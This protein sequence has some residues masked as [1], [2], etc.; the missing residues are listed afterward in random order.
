MDLF[1]NTEHRIKQLRKALNEHNYKYYVLN[2]PS[3]SD[4]EYDQLMQ[5]LINLESAHPEYADP[6]SPSLRIGDDRTREFEQVVHKYPVLSLSNT[7][8][9]EEIIEFENRIKKTGLSNYE[10]VCELKYDGASISLTYENGKLLQAVT[11]GDGVSGDNIIANVKTIKSIPL[12]LTGEDY[13]LLFEIRGEIFIPHAGFEQMNREREETGEVPFANPRNAASGTLKIQNSSLVAKRKLDCFLYYLLGQNLPSDSHYENLKKAKEWGFKISEHV[14]KCITLDDVFKF[15]DYWEDSRKTLPYD[16]DGIVIKIDSYEQQNSLG[17]TA[18]SPRWA[19]AFKYKAE[20]AVT[21]L[22]SIDYQV[23]RTGAITPVANLEPVILA[24]TTVKRASLHNADQIIL[25][26]VRINDIV[27]IE[28]GGEIIPKVVGVEKSKRDAGSKTVKYIE[29][30]PECGTKLVRKEGEAKHYCPNEDGCPPQIKGKIEH[31]VSRRA[32][33]I[34]LAEAT[35]SQLYESGLVKNIADLYSLTKD[36]LINLERFAD[37]SAENL[38]ASINDS[39]DV[40]FDR[41]LYALGIRYAGETVAKKIATHFGSLYKLA[42]ANF[43]DL[44]DVEE[45]GDKIAESIIYYFNNEKNITIIKRLKEAGLQLNIKKESTERLS[46]ILE[47]KSIIISGVFRK[48][49]RDEIKKLIEKNGGK[50]VSSISA[51]TDFLIAGEKTGPSKL[52]KAQKLNI[53]IISED[54]FLDMINV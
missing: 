38:I 5:E 24:G 3:I 4:F 51:R 11:R 37:K 12:E 30:C 7:Y 20:Q 1:S 15:I 39:K 26:D 22:L 49:S 46:D 23:G 35:I 42:E 41:V 21:R 36:Q 10:Y 19:I 18:K 31:F 32:M 53:K 27:Y 45:I 17:F 8:S 40:P 33:D 28:K 52:E 43:N 47:G 44:I 13:P 6:N 14:K 16:I 50:N 48:Y 2:K 34:G 9:K 54:E 25:L 29:Y